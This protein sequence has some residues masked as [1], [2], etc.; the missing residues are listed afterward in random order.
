MRRKNIVHDGFS[1]KV[2]GGL[3][4]DILSSLESTY[5]MQTIN[6]KDKTSCRTT[7]PAIRWAAP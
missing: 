5:S 2:K 7:H 3:L 1:A 6:A 4:L